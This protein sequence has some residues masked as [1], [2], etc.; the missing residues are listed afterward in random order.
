MIKKQRKIISAK[1]TGKGLNSALI[2]CTGIF[3]GS[4]FRRYQ[5][6]A[7][8]FT[9]VT[10]IWFSAKEKCQNSSTVLY[11]R[12][13]LRPQINILRPVISNQHLVIGPVL[14]TMRAHL[15][16]NQANFFNTEAIRF[17][18]LGPARMVLAKPGSSTKP[19]QKI[20]KMSGFSE[21]YTTTK[22]GEV[23][24][25]ITADLKDGRALNDLTDHIIRSI[26][27]RIIAQRERL[28]R[29]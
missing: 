5:S 27:K 4:I 8:R 2:N 3:A 12:L 23:P 11:S 17:E 19:E 14:Q 1:V 26:D 25:S 29:V 13:S 22:S 28:G 16:V 7:T 20:N 24:N 15:S 9:P 21:S 10:R 6:Q 18:H